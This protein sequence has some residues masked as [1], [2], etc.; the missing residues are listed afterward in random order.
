MSM[1]S[2]SPGIAFS[3]SLGVSPGS[4]PWE[5][6]GRF[7]INAEPICLLGLDTLQGI[8]KKHPT[9]VNAFLYTTHSLPDP[10]TTNHERCSA[11][12]PSPESKAGL[13]LAPE[14]ELT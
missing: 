10:G 1:M 14:I 3:L 9:L 12:P 13:A 8:V 5:A 11:L 7:R 6:K 2:S 4:I